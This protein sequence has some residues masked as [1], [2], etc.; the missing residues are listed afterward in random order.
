MTLQSWLPTTKQP[1]PAAGE[2]HVWRI[3]LAGL[4]SP[5]TESLLS[6]DECE[7]AARLL[8]ER[9]RV[10]FIAG[11]GTLRKVLGQYLGIAPQALVFEYGPHGKPALTSEESAAG[12]AF[13]FSHSEDL[14]L[15]AVAH[16]RAIGI[17]IEHRQRNIS[18]AS[19]ARH[20]LSESETADL[21]RLPAEQHQQ[22]L[23]AAWTRKEAYLKALGIGL[24]HSMSGFTTGLAEEGEILVRPLED[25]D[26]KRQPWTLIPLAAQPD[27]LACLAAPGHN[28][29]VCHF[30]WRPVN[31]IG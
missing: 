30:D 13:N 18:V 14:A 1:L 24:S 7:R 25:I 12:L 11:R 6:A 29:T 31:S 23:L 21:A 3:D 2:I 15:L 22:A 4:T 16:A 28:W 9:K 27:Y 17:D 20:I 19:F 10:R 5:A 8:I 26:G